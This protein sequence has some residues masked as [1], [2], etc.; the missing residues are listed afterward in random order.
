[1]EALS[2]GPIV[3]Y[4]PWRRR[5]PTEQELLDRIGRCLHT[6]YAPIPTRQY[7][8]CLAVI[9]GIALAFGR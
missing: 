7:L 8:L 5:P 6:A 3:K 9:A 1:M 4:R 2:G